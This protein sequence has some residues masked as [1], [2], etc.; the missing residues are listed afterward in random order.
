M[1]NPNHSTAKGVESEGKGHRLK[2]VLCY[3]TLFSISPK[4][5]AW[6]DTPHTQSMAHLL[7]SALHTQSSPCCKIHPSLYEFSGMLVQS[8]RCRPD[9]LINKL[10]R[11]KSHFSTEKSPPS[12]GFS[13][14]GLSGRRSRG[15]LLSVRRSG[16]G[17]P[18]PWPPC[19]CCW[20]PCWACCSGRR[21]ILLMPEK[22][23]QWTVKPNAF[24][25]KKPRSTTNPKSNYFWIEFEHAS[26]SLSN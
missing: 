19:W 17:R 24:S 5:S 10:R 20:D 6:H 14:A 2:L 9:F 1:G 18:S 22:H 13:S 15:G 23:T 16:W 7:G 3:K 4:Q 26:I 21:P 25:F 8:I 11:S 12:V